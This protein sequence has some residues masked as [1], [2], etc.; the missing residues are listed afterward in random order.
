MEKI[1]LKEL[2]SKYDTLE[3]T[4]KEIDKLNLELDQSDFTWE[5]K[6]CK[7][8][9]QGPYNLAELSFKKSTMFIPGNKFKIVNIFDDG[10]I[11]ITCPR[12]FAINLS[13]RHKKVNFFMKLYGNKAKIKL[14]DIVHVNCNSQNGCGQVQIGRLM[15]S[16]DNETVFSIAGEN[17]KNTLLNKNRLTMVCPRC[18]EISTANKHNI[19]NRFFR[20][21]IPDNLLEVFDREYRDKRKIIIGE[22]DDFKSS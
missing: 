18:N 11:G 7:N 16:D 14:N 12:C 21:L 22:Q 10:V 5:C 3:S 19:F 9:K 20:G 1:D 15:Q 13:N 8:M 6:F 4:E 17:G 2:A